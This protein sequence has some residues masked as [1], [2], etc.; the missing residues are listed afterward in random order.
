[1]DHEMLGILRQMIQ[2]EIKSGKP[3]RKGVHSNFVIYVVYYESQIIASSY[4]V[5]V[6][7]QFGGLTEF[8]GKSFMKYAIL[9]GGFFYGDIRG[10]LSRGRICFR[11]LLSISTELNSF[12]S[13][14]I[15]SPIFPFPSERWIEDT[16]TTPIK[17]H[18]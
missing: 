11:A 18:V 16:G 2:Q 15:S 8:I 7:T 12:Q 13:H 4:W 17:L 3:N 6:H 5:R 14:G 10:S 9:I 1:M